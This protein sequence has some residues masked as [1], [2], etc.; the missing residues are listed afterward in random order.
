MASG[1]GVPKPRREMEA[2]RQVHRARWEPRSGGG[3]VDADIV[4]YEARISAEKLSGMF[5]PFKSFNNTR[6]S[7][8]RWPG[9]AERT[10]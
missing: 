1:Q 6:E 9:E 5:T 7:S 2:N 10:G 3:S 4:S 8:H